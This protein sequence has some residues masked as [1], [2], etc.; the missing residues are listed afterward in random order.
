MLFDNITSSV[1]FKKVKIRIKFEERPGPFP[2]RLFCPSNVNVGAE[3]S[4]PLIMGDSRPSC[5][6]AAVFRGDDI[7]AK[8]Y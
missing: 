2:K 1:D 6:V 3:I 5:I 8:V 4:S 7:I